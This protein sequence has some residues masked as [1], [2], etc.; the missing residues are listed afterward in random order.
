MHFTSKLDRGDANPVFTLFDEEWE[1]VRADA[2]GVEAAIAAMPTRVR[3]GGGSS[4][5]DDAAS[6]DAASSAADLASVD[7][8]VCRAREG[9]T[10]RHFPIGVKDGL[11]MVWPGTC[12]PKSALP[13][14]F[15]PPEGYTVHA[16]LI[17]EDVPVEH[18]LLMENLL[19][20]AH[21]PFTHTG[22]FAKGWGVPNS[23]SLRRRGCGSPGTGGTTWPTRSW[24]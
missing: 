11:V 14:T 16:E 23:S 7:G 9:D 1:L 4:R 2:A 5:S 24:G 18:G 22:T 8:W 12:A 6:D 21:A 10:S 20:L 3:G 17:I 13:G 15:K 19:D